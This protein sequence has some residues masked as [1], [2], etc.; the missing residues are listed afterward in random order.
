MSIRKGSFSTLAVSLL[1]CA[2]L[3]LGACSS[4]DDEEAGD[5]RIRLLNL[6]VGYPTL[7]L[8]TNFDADDDDDDETQASSVAL[9]TASQYV[10]LEAD[11]YTI[12]L[13]RTGSG[14]ILR[15]FT[16]EQL[17]EGTVNTYVAFGEVGAFGALRLD[18]SLDEAEAGETKLSVANVSSAGALDVYITEASVDLDDTTPVLS[19]VGANFVTLLVDSGTFRL[20]VT[21]AGDTS[22][23][24]LDVASFTL[25]DRG[26]AALIFT[27]TQGGMLANA[28]YMPQEGQPTKILNNKARLRGAIAVANGASA[29]IQAGGVTVLSAATAGVI[30]SRYTLLDAG[31]VPVTLAVNGISVPVPD[32]SLQAG[33]DYTLLVWSNQAGTQ[34]SLLVDDNRLPQSSANTKLRL[35]NGMSTLGAPL[36]LSVDFSPIIEGTLLG[37]VSDELEISSGTDR[38]FDVSNTSTAANVLSR[39]SITLQ[40]NSVYTFFMT[41]TGTTPIG[42][43]RRDR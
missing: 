24:R 19:S 14:S 15:S 37:E 3:A 16:G 8:I 10:T 23:V 21:A 31:T 43:L 22:D 18:D 40:S 26:V 17:V 39:G 12:K 42:V 20:R 6:S 13:K 9:D 28:A 38:Q 25:E 4:G 34:A 33:A 11:D 32:Q 2:A 30:G 7:D 29:S 27:S 1:A 36:T 5:A 41:D 35:L